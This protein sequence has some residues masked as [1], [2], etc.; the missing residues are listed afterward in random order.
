MKNWNPPKGY[1]E[2]KY[3]YTYKLTLKK[4]ERYYYY[5]VHCT[6]TQPEYDNYF[7]S[8]TNVKNLRKQYGNDCFNKTILAFYPTK[9]EALLA[10]DELV[11]IE[12]LNDEFC[13]NKIQGGGTF[14]TT[15]MKMTEEQKMEMSK[16]R[17]GVKRT[18]SSIE[19]MIETRRKRGTDKHN[20]ETIEKLSKINKNKI[21]IYKNDEMKRIPSDEL[22]TYINDGWT[23]GYPQSRNSKVSKAKIGKN[24]PMY[25]VKIT[26]ER[27]TKMLETK[28]KNGTNKHSKETIEKLT[29]LNRLHAQDQ[30]FRKKISNGLK[31][32]NVWSKGRKFIH[33]DEGVMKNVRP[34]EL[35]WYLNNGWKMGRISHK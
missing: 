2:K 5:G 28:L 30:E 34:D 17:K 4:D 1:I 15:G 13:L 18:Q 24:N 27:R 35:D 26:N 11:P 14:D 33:N 25:G 31:G 16:K 6:N 22:D 32:K 8:G 7:G 23:R 19:K 3:N 10:E 29:E 20:S 21:P 9:K 12:L